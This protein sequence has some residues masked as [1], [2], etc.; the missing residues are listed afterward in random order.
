MGKISPKSRAF[1]LKLVNNGYG[2]KRIYKTFNQPNWTYSGIRKLVEKIHKTGSSDRIV[3]SGRPKSARTIDNSRK[4]VKLAISP[5]NKIGVHLS[6]RKISRKLNISQASVHRILKENNVKVFKRVPLQELNQKT[7]EKRLIRARRLLR[8]IRRSDLDRVIFTDEKDFL[9]DTPPIN[10]QN[11]RVYTKEKLKRDVPAANLIFE[12][13]HFPKKIMVWAGV[14]KHGKTNIHF[15]EPK[16]KVD[17]EKYISILKSAKKDIAKLYPD[18]N[19]L[20]QQDGATSHT[21]KKSLQWITENF[22]N[23]LKPESWPPCSPDLNV[24]DYYV[25]G[26]LQSMVYASPIKN[27]ACLKNRIRSCWKKLSQKSINRAIDQF[28]IRLRFVVMSS[29]GHCENFFL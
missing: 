24:M 2:A 9:I 15:I 10:T 6:Q 14:S 1:V 27:L 19:F 25:W 4:V 12:R 28:R 18:G 8:L 20:L 26:A 5:K 11:S 3:G 23:F 7:R 13:K 22:D 16:S 17:S 29:G 21:S